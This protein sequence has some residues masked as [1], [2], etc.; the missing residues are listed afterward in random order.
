MPPTVILVIADLQVES[1]VKVTLKA[2][3]TVGEDAAVKVGGEIPTGDV[4]IETVEPFIH[5][6]VV[7]L[8]VAL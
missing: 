6:T 2:P 5:L 3:S 8:A 7:L 1:S 4:V